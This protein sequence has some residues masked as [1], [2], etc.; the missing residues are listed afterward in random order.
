MYEEVASW[1][2]KSTSSQ[3]GISAVRTMQTPSH[4]GEAQKVSGKN[5]SIE[6]VIATLFPLLLSAEYAL[7]KTIFYG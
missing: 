2:A 3:R 6:Q 7:A 5:Y 1:E 4:W